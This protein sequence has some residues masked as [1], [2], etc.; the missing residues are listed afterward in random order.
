MK[1]NMTS[2]EIS[3]ATKFENSTDAL[4]KQ[5]YQQKMLL[6][7]QNVQTFIGLLGMIGNILSICVFSSKRLHTA[8]YS[9]YFRIM[10]ISDIFMLIHLF[11]HWMKIVL[12]YDL[13]VISLLICQLSEYQPHVAGH[14]SLILQTVILLDRLFTIVYHNRFAIFKRKWFQITLIAI[15]LV[16]SV[17]ANLPLFL[18]SKIEE[19]TQ[20]DSKSIQ[21]KCILP[22]KAF[23]KILPRVSL[24]FPL[25]FLIN[26][27]AQ[28]KLIVYIFDIR[29]KITN[30][31]RDRVLIRD[32]KFAASSIILTIFTFITKLP[33]AI[34]LSGAFRFPPDQIQILYSICITCA[35]MANASSFYINI[36]FN[37]I[38]QEEFLGL[39]QKKKKL[40]SRI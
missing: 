16:F 34:F 14:F 1:E 22:V 23:E 30:R 9:F 2:F 11:R 21:K 24:E 39:F 17:I 12:N 32:L 10:A 5:I 19:T 36:L 20:L 3:I 31:I 28:I 35:I 27:F 13:S 25:L 38:F 4:S 6:V 33:M 7:I 29:G 40:L 15:I 37:S 26:F 18:E 8:S